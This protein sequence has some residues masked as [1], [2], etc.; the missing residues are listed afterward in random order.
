MTDYKMRMALEDVNTAVHHIVDVPPCCPRSG[1]PLAGSTIRVSYRP[2]GIVFPVEHL[3]DMVAEYVNG[4]GNIREM[5]SMVQD[6]AIRVAG[7]V[8]VRVRVRAELVINPPYGGDNQR[9]IVTTIGIPEICAVPAPPSE[10][11]GGE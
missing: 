5:E 2:C 8:E 1:N 11:A 10:I 4:R 3:Q 7:V 6:I 9:M